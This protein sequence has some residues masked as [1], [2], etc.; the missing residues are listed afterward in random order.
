MKT[1]SLV[2]RAAELI[3]YLKLFLFLIIL[4]F[5][6]CLIASSLGQ[7]LCISIKHRFLLMPKELFY[8]NLSVLD[9]LF[10]RQGQSPPSHYSLCDH[11]HFP[12]YPQM[13]RNTLITILRNLYQV[14][15]HQYITQSQ[16]YL[17]HRSLLFSLAV[18]PYYGSLFITV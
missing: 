17:P 9:R 2:K 7:T 1:V 13:K 15:I 8:L 5:S 12:L 4:T 6:F 14:S 16:N 3:Q 18:H 10:Q 11:I